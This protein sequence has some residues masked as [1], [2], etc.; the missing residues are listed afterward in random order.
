MKKQLF[1][2]QEWFAV[3]V[4]AL[5]YFVDLFDLLLFSAI[6]RP[7][8][9]ALGVPEAE[10][11]PVGM[12]LLNWQLA[13]LLLGGI[14]WGVL[15]DKRGRLAVLFASIATYSLANLANAFVQSVEVYALLRFVAGL[16]LAGE[17]GVGITLVSENLPREKR[18][19]A[20]LVISAL[21]LCGGATAA[22]VASKANRQTA[23]LIGGGIGLA[24]LALRYRL[25]ESRIFEQSATK[26]AQ[27]G[28]LFYI[29]KTPH[30]CRRYLLCVLSGAPAFMFTALYIT[31]SPEL[32]KAAGIAEPVTAPQALVS[33]LFAMAASD[34]LGNVL[35]KM[36]ASRKRV[37]L[38]F[39][40]FQLLAVGVLFYFPVQTA[41]GFYAK[42]AL[43]G[44][45]IG[46]WGVLVTNAAE[47]FGTN[48][49]ATVTTSV[50]NFFRGISIP[51]AWL[52]GWLSPAWG[53][54]KAG[55]AVGF[56]FVAIGLFAIW[57]LKDRFEQD[58][59]F[60]E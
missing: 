19:Y 42:C 29:L 6:R 16:G 7:S 57:G 52:F 32:A 34:V 4:V 22:L 43:L 15:A 39:A 12:S 24:L 45:S 37:L 53:M 55:A 44:A 13:G 56:L 35:S 46:Y 26:P 54:A 18:T 30:L 38:G 59:D 25:H 48:L 20:T 33:F 40:M 1:T 9:M 17:L 21:G 3:L 47:Q 49:R 58:L 50:T 36:T 23:F 11:A 14:L 27:K 51:A 41:A 31:L 60:I 28:D 5:G 10:L 8:L 2:S